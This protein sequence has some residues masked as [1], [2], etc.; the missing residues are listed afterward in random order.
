MSRAEKFIALREL[1]SIAQSAGDLI[2][3]SEI[4]EASIQ[5]YRR[6][7]ELVDALG[8][9]TQDEALAEVAEAHE[10]ELCA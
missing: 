4:A 8:E 9:A 1:V 3:D 2:R 7:A 10:A 5:T 6:M